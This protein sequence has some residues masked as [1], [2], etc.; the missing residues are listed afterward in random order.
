MATRT[1]KDLSHGDF[2]KVAKD[3]MPN[4]QPGSVV[5]LSGPV[6][7]GKTEFVKSALSS[8]S[9]DVVSP[10]YAFHSLHQGRHGPIH[11]LDLYRVQSRED[12]ESLGFWEFFADPSAIVIIEWPEM[13][14]DLQMPGNFRMWNVKISLGRHDDL[15]SLEIS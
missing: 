14:G 4:V 1:W 12:L 9:Q 10:T 13:L 8:V 5:F 15:R 6:G 11:H 7:A 2:V 3:W